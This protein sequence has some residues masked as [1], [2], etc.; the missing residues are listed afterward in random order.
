M[1][2]PL[3]LINGALLD[4]GARAPGETAPPEDVNEAFIMLNQMLDSWSNESMVV[5]YKQ[6][7][8]H[9]ITAGKYQYTIGP[10]SDTVA[11]FTASIAPSADGLTGVLTVT[12]VPTTGALSV[13]QFIS[14]TG[15]LS[16]TSIISYGTGR[17]GNGTAAIGTYNLNMAQTVVSGPISSYVPRP[18]KIN[19]GF[20]RVVNSI[21]GTLDYPI[22][23]LNLEKYEQIGIKTLPGPWPRA[24]YYQP[25]EPVGMLNYWPNPSQGEMHLFCDPIMNR[26][27]TIN[28]SVILPQGFEAAVR[29]MLGYR[30]LRSYGKIADPASVAEYR[31]L[32]VEAKALIKRSNMMPQQTANFDSVLVPGMMNDAGFIL[33]GGF[34]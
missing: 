8:I 27:N 19:S 32:A 16:G 34:R 12:T 1:T 21:T 30:L 17:G 14:G 2:Q 31:R 28:D 13:G 33:H 22:G 9:E 20:V 18:L 3:D 11:S 23:I 7:I 25:S 5:F 4:I 29:D 24:V 10:N 6:E 15:V 26:F